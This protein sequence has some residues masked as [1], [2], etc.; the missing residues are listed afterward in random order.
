MQDEERLLSPQNGARLMRLP[1]LCTQKRGSG[2]PLLFTCG[3]QGGR[4]ACSCL[5]NNVARVPGPSVPAALVSPGH[6][7]AVSRVPDF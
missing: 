4:W 5:S 1:L 6:P 7:V 3:W 2:A